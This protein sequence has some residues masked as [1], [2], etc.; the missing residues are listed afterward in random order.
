M[1]N[2]QLK[3]LALLD[4]SIVNFSIMRRRPKRGGPLRVDTAPGGARSTSAQRLRHQ[5][6]RELVY[7]SFQFNKRSQLFIS[8]HNVTPCVAALL[9]VCN[10]KS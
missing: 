4:L 7:R 3:Q 1:E 5:T 6:H 2:S 10:E 8:S 9:R